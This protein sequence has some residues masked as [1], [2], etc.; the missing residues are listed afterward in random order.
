MRRSEDIASRL[1]AGTP[2]TMEFRQGTVVAWDV[3]HGTNEVNVGGVMFRDLPVYGRIEAMSTRPGDVVGLLK[4]RNQYV[5]LGLIG[6]PSTA[7]DVTIRQGTLTVDGGRILLQGGDDLIVEDGE[8]KVTDTDG[9]MAVRLGRRL[10]GG[11]EV[12]TYHINGASHFFAGRVIIEATG[13]IVGQGFYVQQDDGTD[14][15]GAA[16]ASP[17]GPEVVHIRDPDGTLVF[18]TKE[19]GGFQ[20]Q[21]GA[22]YVA[23]DSDENDPRYLSRPYTDVPMYNTRTNGSSATSSTSYDTIWQG[24]LRLTH[25]ALYCRIW[26]EVTSGATAR[27]QVLVN[28]TEFGAVPISSTARQVYDIG[29]TMLPQ[30]VRDATYGAVEVEIRARITSGTGSGTVNCQPYGIEKR[31]L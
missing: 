31:G 26:A 19:A 24:R 28:Q 29:P 10:G 18:H 20:L 2:T 21:T 3:E 12:G 7:A 11:G 27:L 23:M 22:G 16:P 13:E 14:L 15:I 4:W 6:D 5:V 30:A 8:I 9:N 1:K 17:G 25:P